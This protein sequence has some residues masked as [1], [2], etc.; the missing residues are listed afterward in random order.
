MKGRNEIIGC[1]PDWAPIQRED[2]YPDSRVRATG[3]PEAHWNPKSPQGSDGTREVQESRVYRI[4]CHPAFLGH[5]LSTAS[6]LSSLSAKADYPRPNPLPLPVYFQIRE[7]F[8]QTVHARRAG[9]IIIRWRRIS[10]LFGVGNA[11]R[12]REGEASEA[13]GQ[14]T[15]RIRRTR[16]R[17][18]RHSSRSHPPHQGRRSTQA[19]ILLQR[20]EAVSGPYKYRIQRLFLLPM[21]ISTPRPYPR[22]TYKFLHIR[23][24]YT[25]TCYRLNILLKVSCYMYK[26]S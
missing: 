18:P 2:P 21:R 8:I 10:R 24:A 9:P 19:A 13:H 22:G 12:S 25:K 5:I 7:A 23:L 15:I 16:F 6:D 3:Q 14:P 17:A 26:F 1:G 20:S 11:I 4:I